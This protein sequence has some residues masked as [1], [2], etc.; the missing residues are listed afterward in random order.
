MKEQG[1]R[2]TTPTQGHWSGSRRHGCNDGSKLKGHVDETV[3]LMRKVANGDIEAFNCIYSKFCPI[4]R[5]FFANYDGH[6]ISSDDCTQEVFTRLWQMRKSFKGESLFITYL[7]SMA[8]HILNEKM[9]QTHKMVRIEYLK[10][11]TRFTMDF[12]NGL[13]QP[14]SELCLKELTAALERIRA[15]LTAEQRQALE[16]SQAVDVSLA[17]KSQKLGCSREAFRSRL[18]RVRKRFAALLATVLENE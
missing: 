16:I 17:G 13:S 12:H 6:H 18:K 4:L 2:K 11:V 15:M 5:N 14:E 3:E 1:S 7:L 8:R 9:R 10:Q